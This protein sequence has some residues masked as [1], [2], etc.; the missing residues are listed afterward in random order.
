LVRTIAGIR[1]QRWIEGALR[2]GV[3]EH[4]RELAVATSAQA[5]TVVRTAA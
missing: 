5:G 1:Y 4:D 2:N 3:D